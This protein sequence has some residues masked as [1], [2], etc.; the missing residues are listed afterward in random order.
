MERLASPSGFPQLPVA[1]RGSRL[2]WSPE[3]ASTFTAATVTPSAHAGDASSAALDLALRHCHLFICGSGIGGVSAIDL[4]G[5]VHERMPGLA[6]LYLADAI[7]WTPK[8][9]A[10]LPVDVTILREPFTAEALRTGVARGGFPI[11]RALK[12]RGSLRLCNSR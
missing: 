1:S 8:L 11:Y 12:W 10:R 6:I 9:V 5:D 2:T 4:I 7:R 3:Q